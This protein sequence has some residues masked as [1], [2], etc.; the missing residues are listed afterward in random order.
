MWAGQ[1]AMLCEA[2]ILLAMLRENKRGPSALGG[3]RE[4]GQGKEPR[5][6]KEVTEGSW[7]CCGKGED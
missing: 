2:R 1:S 4:E 5:A 3:Q 7:G 6:R